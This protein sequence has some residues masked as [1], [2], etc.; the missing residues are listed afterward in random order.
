VGGALVLLGAGLA[1]LSGLGSAP[2]AGAAMASLPGVGP[3]G[4][5]ILSATAMPDNRVV[6]CL[7]DASRDR[8]MVYL[9]DANRSRLR[10]L[11]VRDISSDWALSDYNND[12]P[13][14]KDIRARFE[15]GGAAAESTSGSGAKASEPS[16]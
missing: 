4:S 7:L 16:P 2:Q 3:A 1:F 5:V 13:L 6:I 11:A 10:L 8:L 14:P 12:A 9:T 15:K